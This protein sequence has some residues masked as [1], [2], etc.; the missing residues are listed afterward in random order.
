[1]M[2]FKK[3]RKLFLFFSFA[4]L[5]MAAASAIDA[6]IIKEL[7]FFQSMELLESQQKEGLEDDFLEKGISEDLEVKNDE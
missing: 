2:N 6:Q 3:L 5:L 1:M 7:E 4:L